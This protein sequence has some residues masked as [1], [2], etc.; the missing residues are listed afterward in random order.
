MIECDEWTQN[1]LKF[2]KKKDEFENQ[3]NVR[4]PNRIFSF[5]LIIFNLINTLINMG[6]TGDKFHEFMTIEYLKEIF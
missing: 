1:K 5:I 6:I 4:V 3:S 2:L